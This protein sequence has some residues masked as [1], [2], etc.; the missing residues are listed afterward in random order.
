[1][2]LT[3]VRPLIKTFQGLVATDALAAVV[4]LAER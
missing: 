4:R 3:T 2:G 1:V